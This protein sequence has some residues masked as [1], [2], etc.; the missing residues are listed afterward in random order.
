MKKWDFKLQIYSICSIRIRSRNW[1]IVEKLE[2]LNSNPFVWENSQ[3]MKS[4]DILLSH[5]A[6]DTLR[7]KF[8]QKA[9]R[10]QLDAFGMYLYGL[11]RVS[12]FLFVKFL[13]DRNTESFFLHHIGFK[14]LY[15]YNFSKKRS[16]MTFFKWTPYNKY[17]PQ[18]S[19]KPKHEKRLLMPFKSSH[20][21]GQPGEHY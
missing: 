21:Y 16:K 2:Q 12:A 5:S 20:F 19:K 18:I 11:G 8:D 17:S 14:F 10:G 9:E 6:F 13:F 15:S 7:R 4:T 3:P 1:D